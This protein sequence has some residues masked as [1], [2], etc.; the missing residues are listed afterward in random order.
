ML[1]LQ[2]RGD[3]DGMVLRR[4]RHVEGGRGSLAASHCDAGDVSDMGSRVDI[5]RLLVELALGGGGNSD[6]DSLLGAVGEGVC[7]GN[8]NVLIGSV[9]NGGR[10]DVLGGKD[11]ND[12]C[13]IELYKRS[14]FIFILFGSKNTKN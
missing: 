8:L 6:S 10:V 5:N 14:D 13:L 12:E 9:L 7:G 4:S 11:H 2:V 1:N 3:G